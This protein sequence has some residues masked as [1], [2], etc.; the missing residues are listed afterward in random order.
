MLDSRYFIFFGG[1]T[2]ECI[3]VEESKRFPYLLTRILQRSDG[4]LINSLNAG[5]SGNHSMHSLL[6]LE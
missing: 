2:T 6:S 3:F 1:S 5:V 4:T